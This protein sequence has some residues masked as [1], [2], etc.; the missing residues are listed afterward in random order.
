MFG[1]KKPETWP[2]HEWRD[3]LDKLIGAAQKA[4]VGIYDVAN[5]LEAKAS[6]LRL[7]IAV[8]SPSDRSLY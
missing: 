6:A 1:S 4:G 3:R 2:A 7:V 5:H 8:S